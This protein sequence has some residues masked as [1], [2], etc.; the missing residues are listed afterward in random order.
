MLPVG[1]EG[2]EDKLFLAGR[3]AGYSW[4]DCWVLSD[5]LEGV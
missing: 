3:P 2:V 5:S 1:A 4:E